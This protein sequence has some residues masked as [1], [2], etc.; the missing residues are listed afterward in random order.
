MLLQIFSSSPPQI[1]LNSISLS[2]GGNS[3]GSLYL[4]IAQFQPAQYDS[5]P[6]LIPFDPAGNLS[7]ITALRAYCKPT[8]T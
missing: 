1:C 6:H 5:Q 3:L 7:P 8:R 2:Y 4:D